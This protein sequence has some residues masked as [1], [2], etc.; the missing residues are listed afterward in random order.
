M[1]GLEPYIGDIHD[2]VAPHW[3]GI[4][5]TIAAVLCGGF[6]GL[7]RERAQKPAGARTVILICLG[8]AIFTQASILIG[9]GPGIA[10][11]ARIA[12]QIV[13]GIGFL[14][15][16]AIIRDRGMLIGLTTGA[17]IWATA[18]VGLT[19]GAGYVAAGVFF[20]LLIVGTLSA[21][22]GIDRLFQGPPKYTT[23]RITFRRD[24]GKAALRIQSVLDEH[25]YMGEIHFEETA[26]DEGTVV[27]NYRDT[28]REDRAFLP[29]LIACDDII[30]VCRG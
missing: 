22:K 20:S 29:P 28:G 3:A 4:I 10:D 18:A 2:L 7:E 26:E 12:A 25:M 27:L 13:S 24:N 16:G 8:S 21:A 9:G 1:Y 11:R 15:A 19:I 17:G 14:G 6:I 30:R 23:L 5:V